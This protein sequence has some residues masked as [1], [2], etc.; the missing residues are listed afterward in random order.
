MMKTEGR[1]W[2]L[3]T[4]AA[5]YLV[6][7]AAACAYYASLHFRTNA[8]TVPM[9]TQALCLSM[10]AS[11]GLYFLNPW[12]GHK[13]LLALTAL[14]VLA[15]GTSNAKATAFHLAV[16]LVLLVPFLTSR[17]RQKEAANKASEPGVAG[18]PQ[19]QR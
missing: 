4:I 8:G 12:L 13:V 3:T 18:A 9:F 16:L 17:N 14:T 6:I 7:C 15:I 1:T 5:L 10:A 19:V 2:Y 11:A